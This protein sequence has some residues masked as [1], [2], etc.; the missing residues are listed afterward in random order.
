[1]VYSNHDQASQMQLSNDNAM[2]GATWQT[3]QTAMPW[4]LQD[5]GARIATLV[6]YARFHGA[7]N[8]ILCSGLSVRDDIIYDPLAPTLTRVLAQG[9]QLSVSAEWGGQCVECDHAL[10]PMRLFAAGI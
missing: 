3:Y 4:V 2:T 9:A 7:S 6:V 10:V 5:I 1:M 8:N